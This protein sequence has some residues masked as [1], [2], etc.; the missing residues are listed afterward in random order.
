MAVYVN[1]GQGLLIL[2]NGAGRV[3]VGGEIEISDGIAAIPGVA[4]WVRDGT[5]AKK[6]GRPVAKSDSKGAE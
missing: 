5:L 3:S 2:P 4:S 1:K 6:S